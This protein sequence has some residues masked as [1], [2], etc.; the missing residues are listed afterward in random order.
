MAVFNPGKKTGEERRNGAESSLSLIA[1]G[2]TVI[3]DMVCEG[4]LRVEGRIVGNLVCK[5]KLVVGTEGLVE[6][7]VD[8]TNATIE[9]KVQGTVVVR[10]LLQLHETGKI[11]GDIVAEKM[12]VQAGAIFTGTCKMGKE[13]QDKLRSTTVPDLLSKLKKT[14]PAAEADK[15]V[16]RLVSEPVVA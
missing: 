16:P 8:A 2:M 12:V 13:G 5:S 1:Q 4:D 6:G 7:N 10:A 3:G 15:I 14:T 11:M 9:G